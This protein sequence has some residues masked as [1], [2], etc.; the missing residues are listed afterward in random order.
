MGFTVGAKITADILDEITNGLIGTNLWHNV[1]TTWTTQLKTGNNARVVLC[2]GAAG[3]VGKGN[4][5]LSANM[6]AGTKI[7]PVVDITNFS[8]GDK[9]VL[10]APG[11][12]PTGSEV[13]VISSIGAGT[14]TLDANVNITHYAAERCANVDLEIYMAIEVINSA[15]NYYYG[16]QGWWYYG[17]GYHIVLSAS[18]DSTAHTYPASNQATFVPFETQRDTVYADLASLIVVYNLWVENNGNGFVIMGRPEPNASDAN[19]QSFIVVVERNPAKEY[20]DGYTNFFCFT[21]VN[22]WQNCLYD[23]NWTP[24]LWR[25][26]TLLRPF[27]Y[28]Y[29]DHTSWTSYGANGNGLSFVP[30]P[31]YYAFKSTGNN[32]VY[33]VKPIIHNISG[34]TAPIFQSDIFFLWNEG[35]GLID[36]DVISIEG[37]TTKYLCKGIDSPDSTNRLTYAMKFVE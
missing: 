3:A 36:G 37:R 32:K 15:Y 33:Y 21:S 16:N 12:G 26:R 8:V 2:Y 11:A 6:I 28:Q 18:W 30:T 27:A 1:D 35:L 25:N 31:S 23:G 5:T 29:P 7:V 10:G 22:I 19:Q 14:L 9:V 13:R 20:T 4:T 34:Q 24:T 17:K